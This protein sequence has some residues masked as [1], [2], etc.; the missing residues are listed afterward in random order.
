MNKTLEEVSASLSLRPEESVV[1]TIKALFFP[2]T[3]QLKQKAKI[4]WGKEYKSVTKRRDTEA[5]NGLLVL[6][7]KRLFWLQRRGTFKKITIQSSALT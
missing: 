3:T 7:T 2:Y 6:T 4:G 1:K 5:Q